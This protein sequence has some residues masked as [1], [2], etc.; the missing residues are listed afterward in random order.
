LRHGVFIKE[1]NFLTS[2]GKKITEAMVEKVA[3]GWERR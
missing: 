1:K 3:S 2:V